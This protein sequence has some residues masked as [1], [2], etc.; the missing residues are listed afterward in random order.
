MPMNL[1][2]VEDITF[3]F[4]GSNGFDVEEYPFLAESLEWRPHALV[5]RTRRNVT[6][7]AAIVLR[8]NFS[9]IKE[10]FKWEPLVETRRQLSDLPIY[11]VV[12]DSVKREPLLA[13]LAEIGVGIY[14]IDPNRQLTKVAIDRSPFDD[15]QITYPIQPDKQYRNRRNVLKVLGHSVH[16][17]WWLDKHFT[18]HGIDF[19]YDFLM[20]S[21]SRNP[22]VEVRILGS[23]DVN[24]PTEIANLRIRIAA[25][26]AEMAHHGINVEMRLITDRAVLRALHDRYIISQNTVFNVLPTS[27]LVRGQQGSLVL[28]DNP[29]DFLT[30]WNAATAL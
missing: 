2:E 3:E 7:K 18:V 21:P 15:T 9:T 19:L 28:D 24:P 4:F 23:G 27:S 13:E 30:M 11:F 16:H 14:V 22:I 6:S 17:I 25:F 8:E 29:P 20:N 10:P 1:N 5:S 12:P 26:K